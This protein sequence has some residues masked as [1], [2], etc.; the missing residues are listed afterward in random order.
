MIVGDGIREGVERMVEFMDDSPN[1]QY[2]LA[3][4]ELEV[5]DL[6]NDKR[7]VVPQLTLKTKIVEKGVLRIENGEIKI[8]KADDPNQT[9]ATNQC[10]VSFDG[11]IG[12]LLSANKNITEIDF[13]GFIDNMSENG[14]PYRFG[15]TD[16]VIYYPDK[17]LSLFNILP[18]IAGHGA[19]LW[20]K[21]GYW[22]K[23]IERLGYSES[24]VDKLCE[25]LKP[26]LTE[27]S[28]KLISSKDNLNKSHY[29]DIENM[30]EK[31]NEII[32]AL[33]EFKS[34]F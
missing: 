20:F 3:L 24:I 26:Y 1:S 31:Q 33:N 11:W 14:Y 2:R 9:L 16:M 21:P 34:N 25:K 6:G 12:K 29:I 8:D 13:T 10:E 28:K 30:I 5:Y 4:C 7:L 27:A 17:N 32:D 19:Q 15:T 22:Y 18:N 23:K